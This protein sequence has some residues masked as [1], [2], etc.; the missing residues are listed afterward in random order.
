MSPDL[1]VPAGLSAHRFRAMGTEVLVLVPR[2]QARET[3]SAVEALFEEWEQ[4]LSRFRPE[5]V[6]S[7]LNASAGASVRV[8]AIALA[9]VEASLAAARATAGLFDPT[10]GDALVRMGY[11]KS[12]EHVAGLDAPAPTRPAAAGGAWRRIIVDSSAGRVSLPAGCRFDPGGIA[13]GMAVDATLDRLAALGVETA[14]V[15]AGGDLRVRGLPP[16]GAAWNVLVG[17]E[18]GSQ[19]VPLVRGALATS[20]SARR[21]WRQGALQR[22]H[23]VDPRTGEPAASGLRQVTVAAATCQAAEVAATAAFVAGPRLAHGLLARHAL[24]GLLV[25]DDG[26]ELPVGRWPRREFARAA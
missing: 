15:S 25:T 2:R 13:K 18:D 14:L 17:D 5:S 23:L 7:Q 6:V 19:V 8:G 21:I 3:A 9:V 11:D 1:T 24:A 16:G 10:L 12:F 26:R 20:G 22:H 4:V